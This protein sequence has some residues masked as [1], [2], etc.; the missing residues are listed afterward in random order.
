[1]CCAETTFNDTSAHRQMENTE[2]NNYSCF[3]F[4]TFRKM[5]QSGTMTVEIEFVAIVQS[6]EKEKKKTINLFVHQNCY[7]VRQQAYFVIVISE[8]WYFHF[9]YNFVQFSDSDDLL[10]GVERGLMAFKFDVFLPFSRA[11]T[12]DCRRSVRVFSFV[13]RSHLLIKWIPKTVLI[14]RIICMR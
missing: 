9:Q 7:V 12:F 5:P 14:A 4:D 8:M 6:I 3:C 11:G 2:K 10:I 1:M 13:R